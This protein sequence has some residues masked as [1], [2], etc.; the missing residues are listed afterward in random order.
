MQPAARA[1]YHL[2]QVVDVSK[3]I[4]GMIPKAI[5]AGR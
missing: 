5:F 3:G 4:H 2:T 1:N